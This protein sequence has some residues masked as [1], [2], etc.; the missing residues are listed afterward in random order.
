MRLVAS[1]G[2][3]AATRDDGGLQIHQYGAARIAADLARGGSVALRIESDYPWDGRVRL[4]VE[5]GGGGA[6][7]LSLRIPAWCEATTHAASTA[8]PVEPRAGRER[9]RC[10]SSGPGRPAT[11]WSSTCR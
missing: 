8:R 2:H 10:G 6:W 11:S 1:L 9:L 5:E 3:Y 7:T 4:V